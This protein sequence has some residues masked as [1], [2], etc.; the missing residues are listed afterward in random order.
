MGLRELAQRH[1]RQITTNQT[2]GFAW[3]IIITDPAGTIGKVS[4]FGDDISALIDPETGQ[5][6]SGRLASIA[7]NINE[8]ADKGLGLP[9]EIHDKKIKPWVVEF[10]DI[11]GNPHVFKVEKSNPDRALGM[12]T[13]LLEFYEK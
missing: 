11:N 12:V 9:V 6:I 10:D 2:T 8:L 1:N 4:G 5:A 13:C 7:V 3:P